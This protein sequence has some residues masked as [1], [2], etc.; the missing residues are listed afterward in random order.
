MR[1]RPI[2]HTSPGGCEVSSTRVKRAV[3][4]TSSTLQHVGIDHGGTHVLVPQEFL[5]RTDIVTVLQ[6]MRRQTVAT[7]IVTLLIMRPWPKSVTRTIPSLDKRWR[8]SDW[9]Y[10]WLCNIG[11]IRE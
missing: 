3:D 7:L 11:T 6:K 9:D 5:H 8:L 2:A 4:P 10:L 1:Q